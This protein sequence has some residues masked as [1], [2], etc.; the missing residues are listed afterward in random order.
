MSKLDRFLV[1]D[2]ILTLFPNISAVCLDKHLS[3]HRPILLHDVL[4]DYGPT[5]F[6]F[7]QS[8]TKMSGFVSMVT[9]AWESFNLND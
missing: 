1:S 5:P 3:D 7:Y 6:R 8:W 9:Q 4:A 2:G